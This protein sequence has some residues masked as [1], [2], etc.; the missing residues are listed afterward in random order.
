LNPS[1]GGPG[2]K[3]ETQPSRRGFKIFAGKKRRNKQLAGSGKGKRAETGNPDV[4][5]ERVMKKKGAL[6]FQGRGGEKGGEPFVVPEGTPKEKKN[7]CS[8]GQQPKRTSRT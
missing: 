2:A 3:K 7:P 8:L 4:G 5:E 6:G 1:S